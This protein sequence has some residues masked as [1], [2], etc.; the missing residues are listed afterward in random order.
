MFSKP[1]I[2]IN[3]NCYFAYVSIFVIS[4]SAKGSK[5]THAA[6]QIKNI[7]LECVF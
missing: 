6:I 4:L 3:Y 2:L 5:D 1:E 7:C